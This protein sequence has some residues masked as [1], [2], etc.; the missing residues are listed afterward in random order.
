MT[1]Q[2]DDDILV[3]LREALRADPVE[4]DDAAWAGLEASLAAAGSGGARPVHSVR[5]L[6]GR[7]ASALAITIVSALAVS[8]AA[9]A[10]V[11]T[12][13]LPGPLRTFAYSL[14]LPVTSP[15][16]YQAQQEETHLRATLHA[17]RTARARVI[18]ESLAAHLRTLDHSDYSSIEATADGLLREAGVSAPDLN[19]GQAT[20]PPE[21]QGGDA[22][23]PGEQ[24]QAGGSTS[25]GGGTGDSSGGDSVSSTTTSTFLVVTT[26]PATIGDN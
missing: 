3:R 25:D 8:G 23:S 1:Y 16:L 19:P 5:S 6:G 9:A 10:A 4:P 17:H 11:A 13:T 20:A 2:S 21:S 12:N 7:R 18:G 24:G 22:S 26:L 15:G 14:G